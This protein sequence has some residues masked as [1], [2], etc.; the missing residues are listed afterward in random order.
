M[1]KVL[2]FCKEYNLKFEVA[3]FQPLNTMGLT[4][5]RNS[6]DPTATAICISM[7]E[8]GLNFGDLSFEDYLIKTVKENL[9]L[10]IKGKDSQEK[11]AP[12]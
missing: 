7:D 10:D 6:F 8:S 1:L 4:F 11:Q 12:L 2:E 3:Y 5:S 9:G